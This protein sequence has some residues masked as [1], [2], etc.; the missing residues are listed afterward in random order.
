VG[1]G[2]AA[3][4]SRARPDGGPAAALRDPYPSDQAPARANVPCSGDQTSWGTRSP[5][6]GR[7]LADRGGMG[8]DVVAMLTGSVCPLLTMEMRE[9]RTGFRSRR[10][11]PL[12]SLE[13]CVATYEYRCGDCG[14]FEQRMPMGSAME[15][16]ACP[17]CGRDAKRIFSVP[18]TYRTPRRLARMLAREEASR[19]YPEVVD[20][21]PARRRP[22]RSTPPNPALARLPKP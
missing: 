10:L 5:A 3:W 20:R 22:R 11:R 12:P 9:H 1:G 4:T 19:D 15:S 7:L 2:G 13:S 18:M 17:K 8:R 16:L 21:L 14:G 6:I